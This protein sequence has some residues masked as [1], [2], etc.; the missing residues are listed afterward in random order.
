MGRVNQLAI[1]GSAFALFALGIGIGFILGTQNNETP[2]NQQ[3]APQKNSLFMRGTSSQLEVS[4]AGVHEINK[5][6]SSTLDN[7]SNSEAEPDHR[8]LQD[9]FMDPKSVTY[10]DRSHDTVYDQPPRLEM[11]QDVNVR[12]VHVKSMCRCRS[13]DMPFPARPTPVGINTGIL[14]PPSK[15]TGMQHSKHFVLHPS[16]DGEGCTCIDSPFGSITADKYLTGFN[17]HKT[18]PKQMY[19][20]NYD[21]NEM[22]DLAVE[23]SLPLF[24]GV[25]SYKSPLSLNGTLHNWLSHDFFRR[26]NAQDTFVQLNKRSEKDDE[27]LHEFMEKLVGQQ[28]PPLTV[29][30]SPEEN[31]NPGLAISKFCRAAE[32]HPSSHPNGENLLMFLEKDWNLWD[33]PQIARVEEI[34]NSINAL[35]QRG[36]PYI[37][38]SPPAPASNI[39]DSTSWPCPSQGVPWV[40]T[41]SHSH[42]WT[43]TPLVVD[44]SWFLRYMEPFAL[45]DDP[46]MSGRCRPGFQE[47]GYCDWEEAM[48]DGRVAWANS[49]WVL[50]SM[51]GPKPKFFAH[52]EVDK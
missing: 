13:G 2:I 14:Q 28:H 49:N 26:T 52:K 29:M 11:T 5:L 30:G 7:N 44:C 17:D 23:E 39:F 18:C 16:D 3:H 41:T 38:L 33:G 42:R 48:Q 27:V 51:K 47:I 36:V 12:D 43:N 32:A 20:G 25:L 15:A 9:D 19:P 45:L 21:W 46:I 6:S 24:I 31:L 1:L 34:M 4:M 8:R 40:C 37:R 35:T 10:R 22:P 50:A